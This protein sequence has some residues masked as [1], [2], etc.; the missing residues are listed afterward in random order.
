[1]PSKSHKAASRQAKLRDKRR[2]G[3]AAPQVFDAG[4]SEAT[5]AAVEQDSEAPAPPLA[6]AAAPRAARQTRRSRR[7]EAE[8][9]PTYPYLG[10]ELRRIG[11]V[12]VG[13]LAILAVLS[14]L[15]GG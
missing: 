6:E 7:A 12:A 15:L 5:Q 14:F 8:V 13:I 9:A 1:M 4:P 3:K 2:R 11:V 10:G